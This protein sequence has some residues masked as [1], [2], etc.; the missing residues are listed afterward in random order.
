MIG[1]RLWEMCDIAGQWAIGLIRNPIFIKLMKEASNNGI[2]TEILVNGKEDLPIDRS[3]LCQQFI[4]VGHMRP[5]FMNIRRKLFMLPFSDVADHVS[6]IFF[7]AIE[8]A[9]VGLLFRL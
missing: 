8:H 9:R 3:D 4:C 6:E 7:A 1:D 5:K 2:L